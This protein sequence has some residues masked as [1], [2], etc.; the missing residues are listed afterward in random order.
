MTNLTDHCVSLDLARR[1]KELGLRQDSLYMWIKNKDDHPKAGWSVFANSSIARTLT[2]EDRCPTFLASEIHNM[3]PWVETY[4]FESC[5]RCNR[6]IKSFDSMQLCAESL[7][8][9]LALMLIYLIQKNELT[10]EWQAKW[11]R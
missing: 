2:W 10:E 4:Y 8:D 3:I 9:C 7:P 5:W 11:M 6:N 1:L